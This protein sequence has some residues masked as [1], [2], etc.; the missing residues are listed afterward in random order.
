[1]LAIKA[2]IRASVCDDF[3]GVRDLI[4]SI[5]FSVILMA[6]AQG[7]AAIPLSPCVRLTALFGSRA[8]VNTHAVLCGMFPLI[9]QGRVAIPAYYLAVVFGRLPD[10]RDC[11]SVDGSKVRK[12]FWRGKKKV[13][14]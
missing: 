7:I 9:C 6:I 1:M 11:L 5:A 2:A 3:R 13:E 8:V 14:M 10:K 4:T 12:D